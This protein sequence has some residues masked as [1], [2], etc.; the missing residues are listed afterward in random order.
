MT[1]LTSRMRGALSLRYV[2]QTLSEKAGDFV[3]ASVAI[4]ADVDVSPGSDDDH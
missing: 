1:S 3:R 4:A 2:G